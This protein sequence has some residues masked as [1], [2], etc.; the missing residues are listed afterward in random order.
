LTFTIAPLNNFK[1]LVLFRAENTVGSKD[2]L[3]N[4]SV[5]A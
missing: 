1:A 4:L 3:V 5:G 2:R